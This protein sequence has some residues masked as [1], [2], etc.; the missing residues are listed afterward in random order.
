M[1]K[2][3]ITVTITIGLVCFILVS[4]IY[5]QFNTISQTDVASIKNMR[6]TELRT[7]IAK[8]KTRL[9]E[10]QKKYEETISKKAEY[11]TSIEDN[12]KSMQ[13]LEADLQEAEKL[14]GLTD[15][16]GEGIIVTL[17]NNDKK[18]ISAEDLIELVNELR[19][20]GAEA[21]S[22]NN[23]RYVINS[24]IADIDYRFIVVNQFRISA[25]YIV[26]AIGNP[27]YLESGLTAKQYGY[28]DNMTKALGKTVTLERSD[29]IYITKYEGPELTLNNVT[30]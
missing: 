27:N 10:T 28:I 21:I 14:L 12:E 7:E 17:E 16:E 19:I 20:A 15:V 24:Y 1:K 9:E 6:E 3:K 5:I 30:S 22:I 26:R 23:E 29:N 8:W 18:S 4:T 2:G 25:P 13:L 11:E